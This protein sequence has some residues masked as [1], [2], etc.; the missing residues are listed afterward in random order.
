[1][2]N[3]TPNLSPLRLPVVAMIKESPVPTFTVTDA[4]QLTDEK[5]Y[6]E[7][8]RKFARLLCHEYLDLLDLDVILYDAPL[9]WGYG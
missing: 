1:M 8:I 6:E 2:K 9:T 5:K 7:P 4:K 3:D